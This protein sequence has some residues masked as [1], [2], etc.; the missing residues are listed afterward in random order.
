ME[1]GRPYPRRVQRLAWIG[2]FLF[3][4]NGCTSVFFYP[5]TEIR[6]TPAHIGLAYEDVTLHTEDQLRLRG[7][8]LPANNAEGCV[9][10]LHGNAHNMSTHLKM[11][12]WLPRQHM[13]TLMLDYRGYGESQGMPT[14]PSVFLDLDA[15]MRE[16]LQRCPHLPRYVLGQSL[17]GAIAAYYLGTTPWARASL[18]GV[19]LDATFHDYSD[20]GRWAAGR[21]WF[22]WG[23]Q[24]FAPLLISQRFDP[25][26][27]IGNISP[28][29]LLMLH[30]KRD[31]TVPYAFGRK[32]FVKAQPPK[33]WIDSHGTHS[34]TFDSPQTR[35]GVVAF[36]CRNGG[37][38]K[39]QGEEL[40]VDNSTPEIN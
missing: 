27:V 15:G 3:C 4:L 6:K 7:W 22:S 1:D 14:L 28:L 29:P 11:T 12:Q 25:D 34:T 16:L 35:A 26:N 36:F 20:M 24:A 8:W 38:C 21:Y 19:V 39:N 17:G 33:M 10:F 23:F 18:N 40:W 31:E 30:S 9:L 37:R 5:A 32:L 13:H 2:L